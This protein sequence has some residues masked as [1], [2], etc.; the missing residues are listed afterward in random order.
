MCVLSLA[1][2][3]ACFSDQRAN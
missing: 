2:Q 1:C 3:E